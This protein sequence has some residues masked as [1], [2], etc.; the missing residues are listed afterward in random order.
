VMQTPCTLRN[1]G[2]QSGVA[3]TMNSRESYYSPCIAIVW[4]PHTHTQDEHDARASHYCLVKSI[5]GGVTTCF[6]PLFLP[7]SHPHSWLM[8]ALPCVFIF[9]LFFARL[10]TKTKARCT[11]AECCSLVCQ[12]LSKARKR[13]RIG[14]KEKKRDAIH[15]TNSAHLVLCGTTNTSS[16]WHA[17]EETLPRRLL[18]IRVRL[19]EG[20]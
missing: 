18:L 1:V 19:G 16:C 9:S 4:Q 13:V 10:T 17:K 5:Q 7:L 20:R 11:L 14:S 2:T 6:F 12:V 15:R 8:C 3:C